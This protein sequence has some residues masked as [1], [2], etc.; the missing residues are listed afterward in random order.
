MQLPFYAINALPIFGARPAYVMNIP[1]G[2]WVTLSGMEN[3][4]IDQ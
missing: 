2:T 4:W 3:V 1:E